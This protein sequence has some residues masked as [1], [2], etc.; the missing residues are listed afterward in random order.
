M[1]FQLVFGSS[2]CPKS[3]PRMVSLP[4]LPQ[5]KSSS[6]AAPTPPTRVSLPRPPSRV[7]HPAPPSSRSSPA[8]PI[9]MSL[10]LSPR[11]RLPSS[12]P[13]MLS[14]FR[15]PRILSMLMRVSISPLT[16]STVTTP[17]SSALERSTVMPSCPGI[18]GYRCDNRLRHSLHRHRTCRRHR[19][20][21]SAENLRLQ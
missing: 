19:S 13:V 5:K 15:V 11:R 1:S 16:P 20:R 12:L 6:V 21:G 3:P 9:R 2:F 14:L 18:R 17:S 8:S 4:L 10:P 7:S